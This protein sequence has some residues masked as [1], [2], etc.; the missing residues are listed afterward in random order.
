MNLLFAAMSGF[1]K[2]YHSQSYIERNLSE[3]DR[4]IILD[5]KDEYSGLVEA[6]DSVKRWIVGPREKEM[7]T[8]W[9]LDV[10]EKNSALQLAK[11]RAMDANYWRDVCG[12]I[13]SA[14]RRYN[15]TILIV[16]DEAHFV[17]PQKTKTPESITGL[18]TTGRGEQASSIWI[19]QR[20]AK[21]DE[22]VIA[23]CQARMLGGF[24]SDRD[25]RK[26][27]GVIE[28]PVALHNPQASEIAG[29]PEALRHPEHGPIPLRRFEDS[30][31]RTIGS[32]WAYSDDRGTYRRVDTRGLSMKATHYGAQGK[33]IRHPHDG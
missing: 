3:Y 33:P 1:G 13:V 21:L 9:W 25:L 20:P 16:V 24:Q 15:K 7:T 27:A 4:I 10:I 5:Y 8:G 2:S 28:Y 19:T 30:R 12:T 22:T 17:A 6:H 26:I 23:Q 18:A 31:G 14:A 11:Y 32:E 29:L